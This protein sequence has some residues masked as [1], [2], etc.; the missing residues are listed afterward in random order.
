M[1]WLI[2]TLLGTIGGNLVALVPVSAVLAFFDMAS[3][4]ERTIWWARVITH[5]IVALS[6]SFVV[7]KRVVRKRFVEKA[8]HHGTPTI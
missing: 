7:F 8:S 6:I 3:A 5:F 2:F 4:S 1:A